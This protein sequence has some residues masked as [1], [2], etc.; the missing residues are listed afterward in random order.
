VY[1][2]FSQLFLLLVISLLLSLPLGPTGEVG[3]RIVETGGF[4]G[5]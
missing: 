2:L 4:V 1:L 5:C 3:T